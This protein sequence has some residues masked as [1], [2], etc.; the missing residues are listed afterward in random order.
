M[1]APGLSLS[2]RKGQTMDIDTFPA[3]WRAIYGAS[4]PVHQGRAVS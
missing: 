4:D 1:T 2:H 3:I